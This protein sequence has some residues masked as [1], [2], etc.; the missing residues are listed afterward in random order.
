M[1]C[2]AVGHH[3]KPLQLNFL[4]VQDG[5]LPDGGG[6]LAGGTQPESL[7]SL[8]L[9]LGVNGGG[10]VMADAQ[11]GEGF[12]PLQE[13]DHPVEGGLHQGQGAADRGAH[14]CSR[15]NLRLDCNF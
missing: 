8:G 9:V 1:L 4:V 7:V 12:K 14:G 15:P 11:G 10:I 2:E 6:E 3:D 13:L 5:V